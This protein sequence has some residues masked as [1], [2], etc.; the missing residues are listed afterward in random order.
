MAKWTS[1]TGNTVE[2]LPW[3]EKGFKFIS[4]DCIE[5]IGG[6]VAYG[7]VEMTWVPDE[8]D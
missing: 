8:N 2:V 1:S 7:R 4:L 5:I 3:M 6:T